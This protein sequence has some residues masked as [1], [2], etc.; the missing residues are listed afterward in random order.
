MQHLP[1]S[2][3]NAIAWG[4]KVSPEFKKRTVEISKELGINPDFLMAC[5]AFESGATFRADIPN[6]A[7]SG[8][9]GLIQFMCRQR[10]KSLALQ[11]MHLLI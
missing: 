10:Q 5:M 6:K 8:A 3:T 11:H 4:A 9:V 7:G 2:P 1:P